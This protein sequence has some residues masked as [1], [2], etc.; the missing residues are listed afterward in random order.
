MIEQGWLPFKLPTEIFAT[1]G[2]GEH[3]DAYVCLLALLTSVFWNYGDT[4]KIY[5]AVAP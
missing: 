5:T 4:V 1:Y 2:V 3:F